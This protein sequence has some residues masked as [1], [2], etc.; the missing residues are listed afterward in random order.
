MKRLS[1]RRILLGWGATALAMAACSGPIVPGVLT[2]TPTADQS[3]MSPGMMGTPG[4]EATVVTPRGPALATPARTSTPQL[5][6][7]Q[8]T[9]PAKITE[10]AVDALGGMSRFVEPGDEVIVKPNICMANRSPEYAVT[11][12]PEVVATVVRLAREAG[13]SRVRVMDN[14]F[15][16]TAEDAYVVSGIKEAVEEA[17]GEMEVMSSAEFTE[18]DFPEICRDIRRWPVYKDALEADVLI[19]VPIAKHHSLATLTLG[20]KNLMGLI[21]NRKSI[22]A[23]LHQRI[24]D[25]VALFQPD[26][27]VMDAVRVLMEGGP[28]GGDLEDVRQLDTVIASP[29]L[30]AVD[31]YATRFFPFADAEQV[32]YI[33]FCAE[34]GLGTMDLDS[35]ELLELEV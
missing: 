22:H 19:N 14:P 12:N 17:G 3:G 18:V 26:L 1:R 5:V 2:V 24:A 29:D 21:E 23:N 35:V 30:V 10:A 16:G 9:P 20:A 11:T 28:M 33:K 31:A 13:A 32:A 7:A 6:S 8:G 27:T 25:L 34:M 4:P 15:S